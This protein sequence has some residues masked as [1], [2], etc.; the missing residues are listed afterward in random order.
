MA[1]GLALF[2]VL[3]LVLGLGLFAGKRIFNYLGAIITLLCSSIGAYAYLPY[4]PSQ[5]FCRSRQLTSQL[6]YAAA[7]SYLTKQPPD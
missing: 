2:G 5:F 1:A 3:Y 4:R 7:T 6:F